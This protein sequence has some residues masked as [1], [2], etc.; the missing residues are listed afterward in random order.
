MKKTILLSTLIDMTKQDLHHGYLQH[1]NQ[2]GYAGVSFHKRDKLWTASIG[3]GK[4]KKYLGRFK[5]KD[6]AIEA[7]LMAEYDIHGES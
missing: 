7:R 1:N 2:S 5:T 3:G 4:S 6:E